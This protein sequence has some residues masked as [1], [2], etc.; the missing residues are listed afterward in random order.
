MIQWVCGARNKPNIEWLDLF[1]R[2]QAAGKGLWLSTNP[3]E[4]KV[5]MKELRPEG[6]YYQIGVGSPEEGERVLAWMVANT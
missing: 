6:M 2:I 5:Y 3:E 1:K 4:L